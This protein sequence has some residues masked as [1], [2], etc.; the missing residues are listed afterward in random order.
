MN[1]EQNQKP[2]NIE[3]LK[4][5]DRQELA[6]MVDLYSDQVYRV[7]LKMLNNPSDA[8][9]VLQET[10][11]KAMRAIKN[12]QER[13][14]VSTWLY[15]IAVN[16]SLMLIRKQKPETA[17]IEEEPF[18][19]TEQDY[20]PI[21][22]VDW[23]CLPEKEFLSNESRSHLNKAIQNLPSKLRS[24]F[25]LRDIEGLSIRETAETLN[26][27]ETNV[28]TRLLRARMRLREDLTHYYGERLAEVKNDERS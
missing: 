14:T 21:Q 25:I 17:V 22:V 9:D 18:N 20:M 4:A 13:S 8:E 19:N 11:I 12:F 26:L 10:F 27:T 3:L 15:R 2:L 5:G 24:V 16:E 28:K 7:A 6:K 1:E 23:C